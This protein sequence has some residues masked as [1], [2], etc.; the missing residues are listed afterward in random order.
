L[1]LSAVFMRALAVAFIFLSSLLA[2]FAGEVCLFRGKGV[3]EKDFKSLSTFVDGN[4]PLPIKTFD[5]ASVG[6]MS[7]NEATGYA[8]IVEVVDSAKGASTNAAL[9]AAFLFDLKA[10][11]EA[12]RITKDSSDEFRISSYTRELMKE[13]GALLGV[14]KGCPNPHC[15]MS[16]YQKEGVLVLGRNYCPVCLG[17][18]E[19]KYPDQVGGS[20][21]KKK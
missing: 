3:A 9:K 13:I 6:S 8:A 21:A 1:S 11:R 4:L 7:T 19:S 2:V 15:C 18:I 20:R 10:V 14:K 16:E 5:V 12:Y 17:V